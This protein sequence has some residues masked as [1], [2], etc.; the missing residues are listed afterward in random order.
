MFAKKTGAPSESLWRQCQGHFDRERRH[1]SM[2]RKQPPP[3]KIP[4]F[5]GENVP[6]IYLVMELQHVVE[7]RNSI[8]SRNRMETSV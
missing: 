7:G 2:P 1:N 3:I 5:K 4:K 8:G 6:N